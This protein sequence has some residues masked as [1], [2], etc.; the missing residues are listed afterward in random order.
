MKIFSPKTLLHLE[1]G[2][3]L[4]AAGIAYHQL[5]ASWWE[6]AA[7]FLAPDL[8]MLGYLANLKLGAALYNLGHTYVV[9]FILGL[10]GYAAHAPGVYAV[11]VIWIA[12]I[13][14]D[15]LVG[16]GFKYPTH[17]KDTHLGRV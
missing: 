15:R 10:I 6:F 2:V 16:Y 13:G 11:S 9:P 17:F 7:L 5:G 8:F 3:V 12:H 4:T 1:G 14:F